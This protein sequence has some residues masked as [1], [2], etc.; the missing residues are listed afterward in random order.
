[1]AYCTKCGKELPENGV[2][3]CNNSISSNTKHLVQRNNTNELKKQGN[4]KLI[5]ALVAVFVL[6]IVSFS[7]FT[8]GGYK[9]PINAFFKSI[10]KSNI[11]MFCSSFT[12]E[13]EAEA[14]RTIAYYYEDDYDSFFEEF[15]LEELEDSLGKNIK[16]KISYDEKYKLKKSEIKEYED[17]LSVDI[18]KAYQVELTVTAKGKKKSKELDYTAYVGK[19]DGEGWKMIDFPYE[20]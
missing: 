16:F 13:N 19:V 15:F 11:D 10:Q 17:D 4:N 6:I 18:S 12:E 5:L 20:D 9:K 14:K 2:C 3:E 8:V 7:F 1:M